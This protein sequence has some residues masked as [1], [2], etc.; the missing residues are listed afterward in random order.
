MSQENSSHI[1]SGFNPE[2]TPKRLGNK[3]L[4][5]YINGLQNGNKYILSEAITLAESQ[6]EQKKKMAALILDWA[7]ETTHKETILNQTIRIGITGTPGVGKSTFIETFGQFILSNGYR[8]AV[9][10]I[11][12]SSQQTKGSILGDKTRMESLSVSENVYIRPTP[13][14]NTLGGTAAATKD[15]ILLCEATGFNITIIETVGVGQSETEVNNMSDL[16]VLLLQ[17]GAGDEIQGIKRGIV[18]TADIFVI[19]KSDGHHLELAKQ[20]KASYTNALQ[21]FHHPIAEWHQPVLLA[22]ALEGKGL[23]EVYDTIMLYLEESKKSGYFVQKRKQ[24]ESRWFSRQVIHLL[25]QYI[26]GNVLIR[27]TYNQLL[28]DI[29]HSKISTSS[30]LRKISRIIESELEKGQ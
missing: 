24:Q 12:P 20:T 5:Y 30:A 15:A 3:D 2:Y 6:N 14:G 26:F 18:E 17:P 27:D 22:S 16:S 9:L 10:A 21:L 19:N 23:E 28:N 25:E 4:D 1:S 29:S 13:T 7:F 8:L 11:D